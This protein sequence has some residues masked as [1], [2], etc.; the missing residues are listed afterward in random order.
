MPVVSD[1]IEGRDTIR[2]AC[3]SFAVEN[4]GARA[5]T[6]Q[7]LDNQWKSMGEIIPRPAVE[8]HALTGLPGD[9]PEAIVLNLDQ[10][11]RPGGRLAC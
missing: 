9:Y 6:G 5:Q 11:F 2:S 1:A 3:D 8:P 10:P 4:A 7:R